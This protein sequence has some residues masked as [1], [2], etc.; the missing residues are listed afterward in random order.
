METKGLDQLSRLYQRGHAMYDSC[1][2]RV[3]D[4]IG[5]EKRKM[6]PLEIGARSHNN[7]N[8]RLSQC[9]KST[10]RVKASDGSRRYM[11]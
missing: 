6:C 5:K 11:V 9:G 1:R 3:M 4:M 10:F 7:S 2:E 8:K